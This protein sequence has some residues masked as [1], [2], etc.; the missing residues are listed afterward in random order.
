MFIC[1]YICVLIYIYIHVYMSRSPSPHYHAHIHMRCDN[2]AHVM[3][4]LSLSDPTLLRREINRG[5]KLKY[6]GD[7]NVDLEV[8]SSL[9]FRRC[10]HIRGY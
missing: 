10:T 3:S 2:Y 7:I 9:D 1:V 6:S 5:D 4:Q 8:F